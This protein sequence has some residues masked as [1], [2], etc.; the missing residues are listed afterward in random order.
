MGMD[1]RSRNTK[2]ILVLLSV[3]FP[4]GAANIKL[5]SVA[6]PTSEDATFA[7]TYPL[8]EHAPE[9][10][11]VECCSEDASKEVT[12]QPLII[13]LGDST[14]EFGGRLRIE[15][16]YGAHTQLFDG[17]NDRT[18]I[19]ARHS[20]DFVFRYDYGR[21]SRGYNVVTVVGGLR[22]KGNWG[23]PESIALTGAA[24]IKDLEAVTGAHFHPITR[25][26]VW[27]RELWTEFVLNDLFRLP[28]CNK[29]TF[30]LGLFP[31]MVGRGI[32]LGASYAVDPDFLGYY[33]PNAVDQYAPGFL[34]SGSF[35][36]NYLLYDV[37]AALTQNKSDTFNNVNE[38][39]LGQITDGGG[40]RCDPARGFGKV[41]YIIATRLVWHLFNKGNKKLR[42]EPYVVYNDDREQKIEFLG[43]SNSKLGTL[44]LAMEGQIGNFEF[45]FD[46]AFNLGRQQV[47]GTD[48]NVTT[49][50]IRNS[51]ATFINSHVLAGPGALAPEVPDKRA[52]FTEANQLAINNEPAN[53]QNNGKPLLDNNSLINSVHRFTPP[54]ENRFKGSMFIFDMAY[55]YCFDPLVKLSFAYGFATGDGNPNKD[56]LSPNDS[57]FDGDFEG[58]IGLQETYAGTRVKSA[59]VLGGAAKL[60]RILAVPSV[61]VEDPFPTQVA[62][63]SNLIFVGTGAHLQPKIGTLTWDIRPNMLLYWQEHQTRFFNHHMI[64]KMNKPRFASTY[65]GLEFNTFL[66]I[67]VFSDMKFFVTGAVFIPGTHY[68]DIKGTPLTREQKK[69]LDLESK[70]GRAQGLP[71]LG[72]NSAYFVNIGFDYKF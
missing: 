4:L 1:N 14:F 13:T 23:N 37:Y 72:T 46:T 63:F 17:D 39:I 9:L 67:C 33:S 61:M 55:K 48:R 69:I 70:T 29:H 50:E 45:G 7:E 32:S 6:Q 54:Y 65:L 66:E 57:S 47:A 51:V 68:D 52:L 31:F 26:I 30:K 59:M 18:L 20:I 16:F 8:T 42:L 34:F 21:A 3:I 10:D 12:K 40:R 62:R 60:P 22:N 11:V 5:P 2:L 38:Q 28:F 44:G 19:P 49:R 58:F 41:N 36:E 71:V 64:S 56:I 15:G 27:Y 35:I 53:P 43:D 25:H 24:T